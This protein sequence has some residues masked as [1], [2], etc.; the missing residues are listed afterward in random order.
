[1]LG[2][3]GETLSGVTRLEGWVSADLAWEPVPTH[4]SCSCMV[5]D[6]REGVQDLHSP[7][8]LRLGK[9]ELNW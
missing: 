1:M 4:R 8:H 5:G 9:A 6:G 2:P 7:A 3:V